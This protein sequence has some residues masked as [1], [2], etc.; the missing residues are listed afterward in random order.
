MLIKNLKFILLF[1]VLFIFV[2]CQPPEV[3]V[4]LLGGQ[5]NATGQGYMKNLPDTFSIDTTVMIYYSDQ[6]VGGGFPLTWQPL[7]Q[8]SEGPDRFGFELSM[9][10]RLQQLYPERKVA[11]IKHA[12]SGSNLYQDWYP[13]LDAGDSAQF[14]PHFKRFVETVEIGLD[15]LREMGYNPKIRAM[16]W[17]QGEGDASQKGGLEN[18]K[19]YGEHLNTFIH[20]VR[21]QF[22]APD[23]LFVYGYVIPV[24]LHRFTGRKEV[25]EGQWYVDHNS[26][27][28]LSDQKAFVIETDDLPLRCDEPESPYPNDSVHFNTFGMLELGKRFADKIHD[29]I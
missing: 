24:P 8:A 2:A 28:P 11:Q 6:M 21:E 10:N 5:S 9:G 27:H 3:D 26:G 22:N 7:C 20:R 18:S 16:A 15:E 12:Y 19:A 14:G 23:M 17:Q 13:G 25:R 4:Y 29:P 1:P